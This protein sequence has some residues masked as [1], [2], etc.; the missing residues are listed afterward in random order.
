MIERQQKVGL[1][2]LRLYCGRPHDHYRLSRKNG[3][4]FGDRPNI[5]RKLKVSKVIEE[6]LGEQTA[7]SEVLYIVGVEMQVTDVL[8]RLLQTCGDG[9]AAVVGVLAVENV[10]VGDAVG[11]TV[12]K[13]AVAH[14]KLVEIA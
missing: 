4:A 13:I 2:K 6:R 14:R 8:D 5:A 10:E 11:H 7:P 9:K 3:G 12:F 1:K